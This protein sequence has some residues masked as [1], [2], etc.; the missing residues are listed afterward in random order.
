MVCNYMRG[1]VCQRRHCCRHQCL[2]CSHSPEHLAYPIPLS[3]C[4]DVEVRE[5]CWSEGGL[6]WPVPD[7]NPHAQVLMLSHSELSAWFC[8][9]I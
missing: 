3:A 8:S 5:R 2:G 9:Q 4:P 6:V 1:V 7:T